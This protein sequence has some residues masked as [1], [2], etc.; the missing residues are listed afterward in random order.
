MVRV[1]PSKLDLVFVISL[2]V[3]LSV[4]TYFTVTTFAPVNDYI[5]DE[6]WYP[7]SAYN[8]LDYIFHVKPPLYSPW[9]PNNV[10]G[11]VNAEHPPLAKYIMAVFEVAFGYS[12]VAF[13]TPSWIMGDL[14]LLFV[15]LTVRKL[16]RAEPWATIFGIAG[17]IV[18]SLDPILWVLHGVAMLEI[19]VAFF[20]LA[21]FYFLI[22]DR[23]LLASVFLGLAFAS[24]ETSDFLL[25]PFLFYIASL[26][27][28]VWKRIVYGIVIPIGTYLLLNVPI[29][30]YYHGFFGW[31]DASF[32]HSVQW[33]LTTGHIS[34]TATSQIS[35]PWDWFLNVHPFFLGHGFY[36]S[37]SPPIMISWVVISVLV[38]ALVRDLKM[39]IVTVAGWTMWL[40]LVVVWLLGNHTLFSFY[41]ADFEPF[42]DVTVVAGAYMIVDKA[43]GVLAKRRVETYEGQEGGDN[44]GGKGQ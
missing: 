34:Q 10:T 30:I 15:A 32:L 2:A 28:Q 18:A 3:I 24:K 31:L 40:S 20:S 5:G 22:S 11:Y 43:I 25:L 44:G 19:Y 12:F 38:F 1:K 17:A 4:Y 8:I 42:V 23:P 35:T 26:F 13:R 36:A 41:V 33:D 39:N 27:P 7:P 16:V 29:M 14:I 9:T 6:V 21:A 37:T